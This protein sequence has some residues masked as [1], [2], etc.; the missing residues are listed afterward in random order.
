MQSLYNGRKHKSWIIITTIIADE[1]RYC[2]PKFSWT[3][4]WTLGIRTLWA[5]ET[6][7]RKSL[8]GHELH[9]VSFPP[10]VLLWVWTVFLWVASVSSDLGVTMQLHWLLCFRRNVCSVKN[11]A[12][13]FHGLR[14]QWCDGSSQSAM[15]PLRGNGSFEDIFPCLE[16]PFP[17]AQIV[18]DKLAS[19]YTLRTRLFRCIDTLVFNYH[20]WCCSISAL[21]QEQSPFWRRIFFFFKWLAYSD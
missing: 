2:D 12:H 11:L 7:V 19:P 13:T 6:R 14:V 17:Q 10:R 4:N 16:I 5:I 9:K 1:R 15:V 20:R 3:G 8:S 18:E 21:R